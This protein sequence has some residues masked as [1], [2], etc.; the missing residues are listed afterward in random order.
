MHVSMCLD[1]QLSKLDSLR[2]TL[3]G[4]SWLY[5]ITIFPYSWGLSHSC[6]LRCELTNHQLLLPITL[7]FH[8]NWWNLNYISF[9]I[10]WTVDKLFPVML[11]GGWC[12]CVVFGFTITYLPFTYESREVTGCHINTS[13]NWQEFCFMIMATNY[14]FIYIIHIH[15]YIRYYT[16]YLSVLWNLCICIMCMTGFVQWDLYMDRIRIC[17]YLS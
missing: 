1:I 12:S 2:F 4:E 5:P 7:L 6:A 9:L 10:K 3:Y 8:L 11:N 13:S 15:M 16:L 14:A 17:T